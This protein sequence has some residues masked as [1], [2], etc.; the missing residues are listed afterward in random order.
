MAKKKEVILKLYFLILFFYSLSASAGSEKLGLVNITLPNG[1]QCDIQDQNF[2]C[3]D[4]SASSQKNAAVVVTSKKR[5]P[6]DSLVVYRDQLSRPRTL[7]QGDLAVPSEPKMTKDRNINNVLWIES[8]HFGAEVP[9]YYTHYYATVVD[10]YA[11][12]I[13]ISAE[14]ASYQQLLSTLI[15]PLINSIRLST[16]QAGN[17]IEMTTN[18]QN[19]SPASRITDND[20]TSKSSM[21]LFGYTISRKLAYLCAGL[22]SVL[23]LLGYAVMTD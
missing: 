3:L 16:P 23:A 7:Y 4:K 20:S 1:W 15:N 13:S 9:T 17:D 12:L 21:N 22:L 8:I 10:Q 18:G 5:S 6:E 14:K 19:A 2:I 11:V